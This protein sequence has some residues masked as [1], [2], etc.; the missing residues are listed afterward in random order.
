[1]TDELGE[2]VE[3]LVNEAVLGISHTLDSPRYSGSRIALLA[4]YMGG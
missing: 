2:H 3:V 4:Q 1:M